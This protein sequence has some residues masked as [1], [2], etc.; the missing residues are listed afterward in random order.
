MQH[1]TG[2][3]PFFL[4]YGRDAVL[5]TR[6][7]LGPL[8]ERANV[9][10]DDYTREITL[11][12]S[13]AWKAAQVN[14]KEAQKKQ[15]CQHDKKAKDPGV[16]EGDRVFVYCPAEKTGKAYK[17]AR[18]FKGPYRVMKILSNGAELSLIAEPTRPT[19]RV[20][21]NC[22][23]RCPKEILDDPA[24][25]DELDGLGDQVDIEENPSD[26]VVNESMRQQE[27]VA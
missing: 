14:I 8:Q 17:F 26:E 15:K 25:W 3:S 1:S 21:L 22:L 20:A 23:R 2:K 27:T 12:M 19:I 11:R 18:P 13:K 24:E 6:E 5:P 9:D 10:V 16:M 7:M 4:L